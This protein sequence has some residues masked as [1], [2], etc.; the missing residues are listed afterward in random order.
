MLPQIYTSGFRFAGGTNA[1]NA[2]AFVVRL[3]EVLVNHP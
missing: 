1:A 3:D 2:D